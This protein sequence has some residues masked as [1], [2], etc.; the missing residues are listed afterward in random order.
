MTALLLAAGLGL[1][2]GG[3]FAVAASGLTG[4]LAGLL[5]SSCWRR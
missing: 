2:A 4:A 1:I 5:A 3:S